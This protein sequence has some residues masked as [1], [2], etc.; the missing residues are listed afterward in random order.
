MTNLSTDL[1]MQLVRARY[2][3]LVQLRD[4]GRRQMELIEQGDVT[5]LLDVLSVK[6]RPLSDIQRLDKALDPY[7][8]QDPERRAWRSPADR[9]ACARLVQQCE[10]L[11]RE[12][13]SMEKRCEEIMV[14]NRDAT[15][16][17]LQ[18]LRSAGKAQ[19]AYTAPAYSLASQI[20]LSSER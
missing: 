19:G 9:E 8:S 6:Q 16:V 20:D 11:L 1:L 5:A 18:Q 15:A 13:L 10:S 4:L 3:C 17:R 14:R 7:R 2:A 12:I